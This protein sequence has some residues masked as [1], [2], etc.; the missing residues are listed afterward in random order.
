MYKNRIING[1]IQVYFLKE[2]ALPARKTK[3]ETRTVSYRLPVDISNRIERY[4]LENNLTNTE[5]AIHYLRK[6]IQ[7][8]SDDRPITRTDYLLLQEQVKAGFLQMAT[9][10]QN[11]PI[12]VQ[13]TLPPVKDGPEQKQTKKVRRIFGWTITKE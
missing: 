3:R 4:A 1:V 6:G 8:E 11:Q 7:A 9:A 12:S 2:I 10:I 13:A 5:A